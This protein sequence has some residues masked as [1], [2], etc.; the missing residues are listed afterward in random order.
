[1]LHFIQEERDMIMDNNGVKEEC[2]GQVRRIYGTRREKR[3][4]SKIN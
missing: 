4:D 3:S 2:I 1:M